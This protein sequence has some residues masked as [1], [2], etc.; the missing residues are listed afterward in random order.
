MVSR[1]SQFLANSLVISAAAPTAASAAPFGNLFGVPK[2]DEKKDASVLAPTGGGL[3]SLGQ[4]AS[5]PAEGVGR[6]I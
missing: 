2:A 1:S 5:K 6:L 4:P 3:F